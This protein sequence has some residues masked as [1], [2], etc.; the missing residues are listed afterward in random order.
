MWNSPQLI[1]R[2]LRNALHNGS[3]PDT[4]AAAAAIIGYG[5]KTQAVVDELQFA[6]DDPEP[7]VRSNA[8][9]ALAALIVYAQKNPAVGLKI[10][11]TWFV[12]LLHSVEL[13]DR[14][15]SSKALALLTDRGGQAA[16]SQA[17][18]DLL[19]ERALARSGGDG[20]LADAALRAAAVPADGAHR[21]FAG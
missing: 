21:R 13:G 18:L 2:S 11:P 19:R 14:E 17:A 7:A 20:S 10:Q 15:E 8:I 16:M 4:R 5:P 12:E 9:R 3:D 1:W 6:L